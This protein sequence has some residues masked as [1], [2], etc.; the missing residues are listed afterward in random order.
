MKDVDIK[1]KEFLEKHPVEKKDL[2]IFAKNAEGEMIQ[3][4]TS[5]WTRA[6]I[7]EEIRKK[8]A[9]YPDEVK[10]VEKEIEQIE[11]IKLDET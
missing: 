8:I 10:E 11:D 5:F 1:V 6:A 2:E 4:L 7:L 9:E 3:F